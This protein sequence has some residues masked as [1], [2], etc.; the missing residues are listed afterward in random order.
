MAVLLVEQ[1]VTTA[2]AVAT[3]AAV[4]VHGRIVREGPP[5]QVADAALGD[6]L[7]G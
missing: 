1:F 3:Q 2:L 7:S 6:Y 5:S 4:L